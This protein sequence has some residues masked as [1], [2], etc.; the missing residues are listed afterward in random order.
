ALY[1]ATNFFTYID[2]ATDA[3]LPQRGNNKAKRGDLRQVSLAL[4]ATYDFHIPLFHAVYPGNRPDSKEFGYVVKDLIERYRTLARESVDITFI[5]D[6]GNNSKD[7][8]KEFVGAV[9]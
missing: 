7:N 1:D 8:F 2:T 6:K 3:E 5:F 9:K 4:L